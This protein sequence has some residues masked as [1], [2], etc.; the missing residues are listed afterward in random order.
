MVDVLRISNRVDILQHAFDCW[1][2]KSHMEVVV[3]IKV[4]QLN[5]NVLTHLGMHV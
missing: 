1:M 2:C 5:N 3:Q 4:K